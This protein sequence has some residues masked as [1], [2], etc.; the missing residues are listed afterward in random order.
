M[1]Q[2][3]MV[4]SKMCMHEREMSWECSG[5][6]QWKD[7]TEVEQLVCKVQMHFIICR[8]LFSLQAEKGQQIK[9]YIFYD[10]HYPIGVTLSSFVICMFD[11]CG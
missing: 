7:T 6:M 2:V 1:C 4:H 11:I 10:N 3:S 9:I 5:T 8:E